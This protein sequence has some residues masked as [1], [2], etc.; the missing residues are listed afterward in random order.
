MQLSE[1]Q[2]LALAP[3][4][5]AAS[6]GKKLAQ[7]RQWPLLGRS[8]RA[9]WGE[10]QGSGAKPYQVRVDLADFA[11]KCSCPSFK[12]PCK[13]SIGLLVLA[14]NQPAL[15]IEGDE[16]G[17]V[18]DWLDK[19]AD[20]SA[21]KEARALAKAEAPV[22]EAAQ[23]KR[24]ERRESRVRDGLAG[25][26]VWLEDLVRNGLARLPA[27]GPGF[28]EQTAAR[29]VDAQ[30]SGL[31]ARVR[32]LADLPGSRE[33]WPERLLPELGRLA[34]A[35]RAYERID[36]L[37]PDLQQALRQTIGF[38]L[39]E[40]E[41]LAQGEARRDR[42]QVIG[43]AADAD[44]RV[45]VR[46]T[47]LVGEASGRHAQFLQFAAGSQP[48]ESSWLPGTAFEGELAFWPGAGSQRALLKGTATPL[49]LPAAFAVARSSLQLLDEAASML[50]ANP[51]H[52]RI[53]TVLE[54]A[55]PIH[56]EGRWQV[57]DSAGHALPV[58]GRDHW[59][60]M[61]LAGGRPHALAAEWDGSG[62]RPLGLFAQGRYHVLAG[63][64]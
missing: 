30:A 34:L 22:D 49:P 18:S 1:Q 21:R 5:G 57:A 26:Q 10:C 64:A 60:W 54:G 39:R 35:V 44:E 48:F 27:Q 20:T 47:W 4:S 15:V 29:L 50:A 36:G 41:V 33:D 23:H 37:A 58:A 7:A 6:N 13:H 2:V 17:W 51:W 16:P 38:S 24:A 59:L 8:G 45:K 9:V 32:A 42:W 28:W 25:L 40:E 46:R 31:A 3:D 43:Q 61:A 19:R 52:E 14:A 53:A 62:I 12:F 56:H 63:G 55:V 11:S